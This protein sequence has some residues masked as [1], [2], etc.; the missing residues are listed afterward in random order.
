[1]IVSAVKREMERRGRA[2]VSQLAAELREPVERVA[3]AMQLHVERG[4]AARE[5]ATS[6]TQC[7]TVGCTRCPLADACRVDAD[8]TSGVD[9]FVWVRKETENDER[10]IG[11][12]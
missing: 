12:H 9:V 4:R 7:G 3:A 6:I 1:M 2:T 8:A 5:S 11:I 10:K